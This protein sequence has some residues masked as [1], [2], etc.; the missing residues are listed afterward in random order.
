MITFDEQIQ[1]DFDD[2]VKHS[3]DYLFIN[4]DKINTTPIFDLWKTNKYDIYK[5]FGNK[6][7]VEL[8]KE[9]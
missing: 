7:I 4:N 1:K 5:L 8:V 6:L 9:D 3:Q 2:V